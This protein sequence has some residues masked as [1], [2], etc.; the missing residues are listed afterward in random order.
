MNKRKLF[1]KI[2]SGAKN[3]RFKDFLALAQ[4]FGFVLD[5]TSGSHHILAHPN[6][7]ELLNVQNKKGQAKA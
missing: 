2:L 5:R 4:A 7:P 3:V 6:V 1:A